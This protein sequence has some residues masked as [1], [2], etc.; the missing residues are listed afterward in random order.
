MKILFI[1]IILNISLAYGQQPETVKVTEASSHELI[2]SIYDNVIQFTP[3][4]RIAVWLGFARASVENE[5]FLVEIEEFRS[6]LDFIISYGLANNPRDPLDSELKNK[7]LRLKGRIF[8]AN[9]LLMERDF[10]IQQ[11]QIREA[12]NSF[13]QALESQFPSNGTSYSTIKEATINLGDKFGVIETF[14]NDPRIINHSENIPTSVY[15]RILRVQLRRHIFTQL[16]LIQQKNQLS[17]SEFQTLI[18]ALG[19]KEGLFNEQLYVPLKL[20]LN[21]LHVGVNPYRMVT[22]EIRVALNAVIQHC[23]LKMNLFRIERNYQGEGY[24]WVHEYETAIDQ[25]GKE[26]KI[27]DRIKTE[28]RGRSFK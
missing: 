20:R 16:D 15:Y 3:D 8:L 10:S 26:N 21:F 14:F 11:G 17:V 2:A 23:E 9:E 5:Q 27:L 22:N 25:T 13:Y 4:E 28:F 7:L 6:V 12:L 18:Q 19:N 1:A 24:R